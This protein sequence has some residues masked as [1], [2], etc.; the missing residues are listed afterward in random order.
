[1]WTTLPSVA[2]SCGELI[3]CGCKAVCR[4]L[5]K[6]YRASLPCTTLCLCDGECFTDYNKGLSKETEEE[7]EEDCEID[8]CVE[9]TT[10]DE[11]D[12]Y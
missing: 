10:E 2:V 8:N 4:G 5:C 7:C 9:I 1:M 3:S 12:D 11:D 6:C